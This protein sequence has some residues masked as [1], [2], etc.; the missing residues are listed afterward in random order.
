MSD[1]R[2]VIVYRDGSCGFAT[3][4]KWHSDVVLAGGRKQRMDAFRPAY[5][6]RIRKK[7]RTSMTIGE[8]AREAVRQAIARSRLN[9][10]AAYAEV[11][12]RT[13]FAGA[14]KPRKPH[15]WY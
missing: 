1:D 10:E 7:A 5:R 8:A 11:T 6:I 9:P 3:D 15:D 12:G 14:E 4:S 13:T 2:Y